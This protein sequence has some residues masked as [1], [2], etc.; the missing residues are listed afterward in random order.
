MELRHLR[1]FLGVAE[2]LNF[3]RAAE[4]L[5]VAQPALSRQISDL[6]TEFGV[7]LFDRSTKRVQLTEAGRHFQKS[8]EK[9]FGQLDLAV[10]G[11]QQVA[12][13]VPDRLKIGVDHSFSAIPISAA[14][15][16]LREGNPRLA[17]ELVELPG[18]Q[19]L[20]AVRAGVIDLGFVSGFL[21]G[22][23]TGIERHLI[24][25]CRMMALLPRGHAL[26]KRRLL[27]LAELNA[28]TLGS[29]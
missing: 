20:D 14:A 4:K 21:G 9:V 26:A 19:Q 2:A 18:Y 23:R 7:R 3:T 13:G 16:D 25:H 8:V 29:G 6:E 28:E 24:C 27:R 12:R 10:T 17:V 22:S 11:M 1:Y 5:R 15:R